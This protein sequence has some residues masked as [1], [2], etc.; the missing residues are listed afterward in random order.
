MKGNHSKQ[1]KKNWGAISSRTTISFGWGSPQ[2]SAAAVQA[3]QLRMANYLRRL[4]GVLAP[5]PH[6]ID[7]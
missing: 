1:S 5:I 6:P 7:Y 4:C 3:V 2:Y